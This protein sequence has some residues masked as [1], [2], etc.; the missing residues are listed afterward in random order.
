MLT[1]IQVKILCKKVAIDINTIKNLKLYIQT[2]KLESEER[3]I[4]MSMAKRSTPQ[5]NS[6]ITPKAG[7]Q[8]LRP[9]IESEMQWNWRMFLLGSSIFMI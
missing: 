3:V 4:I 5:K 8:N 1:A 9:F 6:L 7:E 2:K